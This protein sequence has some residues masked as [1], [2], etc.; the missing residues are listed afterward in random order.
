MSS[1]S[2]SSQ[3]TARATPPAPTR[4]QFGPLKNCKTIGEALKHPEMVQRFNDAVPR[5]LSA[6][7]MMRVMAQAV[8]KT[9]KLAECNLMSLL[10]AM[11]SLASLGLEPNNALGHA[12]LIPFEKRTKNE[13]TGRWEPS[14]YDVQVVIG[15]KGLIDLARRSGSLVSVHADVVYENDE[16]TFEYGSHMDLRHV[17]RGAREGREP[18]W[19]YC[20]VMLKDGQAF[21]VLP[22]ADVLKIRD[23][24]E[25]YKSAKRMKDRAK[26][27]E[28]V[29]AYDSN[30][31]VAYEHEMAAKTMIR[32][33]SKRLP[34][35][36]EFATAVDLDEASDRRRID[37]GQVI[38]GT[39]YES[40][41]DQVAAIAASDEVPMQP[42]EP[43]IR[44]KDPVAA[45]PKKAAEHKVEPKSAA[46][47]M[48]GETVR[49]TAFEQDSRT[50]PAGT[51]SRVRVEEA[52][53]IDVINVIDD[54]RVQLAD[55]VDAA[56]A[57]IIWAQYEPRIQLLDL[58]Q[59]QEAFQ[60]INAVRRKFSA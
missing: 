3:P 56:E 42:A 15:Y 34:M 11:L 19:S 60:A 57:D 6:D 22:Y 45:E 13:Q 8:Y 27:G 46:P 28:S 44:E 47:I 41:I 16:F 54:L 50:A 49:Q 2:P 33:L 52:K 37:Y 12:Y 20:H 43:A 58:H 1:T 32:R 5:Q 40:T 14:G 48:T 55:A 53:D 25:G 31:W 39:Q 24:S 38:D 21:E 10:G 51:T 59:K 29:K 7:R 30:P 18:I 26:E 4:Q 17:P 35:T 9:P 23:G 36:I